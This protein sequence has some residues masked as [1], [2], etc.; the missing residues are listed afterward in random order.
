MPARRP[1]KVQVGA[2]SI[3]AVVGTTFGDVPRGQAVAY[4][5]SDGVV[6]VAINQGSAAAVTGAAPGAR[7]RIGPV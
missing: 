5:G 2:G 6:E 3:T 7:V 1:V 4:V